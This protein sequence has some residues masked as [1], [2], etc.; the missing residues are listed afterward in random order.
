MKVLILTDSQS[1]C[2]SLTRNN[3]CLFLLRFSVLVPTHITEIRLACI[4]S[5]IGGLE[6]E[7]ADHLVRAYWTVLLLPSLSSF[8]Q[9]C[10]TTDTAYF[11]DGQNAI[12][13][14]MP[15]YKHLMYS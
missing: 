2:Y 3:D 10:T 8:C 5:H 7:P 12:L 9:V 6:N 13:Y 11:T 4:P 15:N 1:V 14:A